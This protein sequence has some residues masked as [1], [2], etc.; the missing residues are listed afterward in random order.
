[1]TDNEWLK[2]LRELIPSPVLQPTPVVPCLLD[3]IPEAD[4]FKPM[5][6]SCPC[7]KCTPWC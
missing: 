6:L 1:M 2:Q 7:P 3:G 4:K 5:H